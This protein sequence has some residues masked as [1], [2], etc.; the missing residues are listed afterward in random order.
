P[1]DP[2]ACAAGPAVRLVSSSGGNVDGDVVYTQ[3]NCQN[4]QD[5]EGAAGDDRGGI[6]VSGLGN[7]PF[8]FYT[9]DSTTARFQPDLTFAATPGRQLDGIFNDVATGRIYD[10]FDSARGE[11]RSFSGI[12]NVTDLE[13]VDITT[14]NPVGFTHLSQPIALNT[15]G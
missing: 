3:T 6:A 1:G 7:Q 8:G 15:N 4:S 14:L 9:G 5:H 12:F 13:E 2:I 11:L 10:L